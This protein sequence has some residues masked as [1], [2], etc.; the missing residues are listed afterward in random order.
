MTRNTQKNILAVVVIIGI[1]CAIFWQF[2]FKGLHPYPGNFMLAWFEPWKS[3][4]TTNGTILIAHKPVADDVFRQLYPFK[5]LAVNMLKHFEVP[6]W[7]PYN[8]SG[9]PLFATM[10][11]G[12]LN[13]FN[14]LFFFLPNYLAWSWYIIAQLAFVGFFTYLY[15]RKI[16]LSLFGALFSS[17]AFMLSGFVVTRVILGEY[18]YPLSIL[19]LLLYSV[20]TYLENPYSRKNFLI[21]FIVLFLFLSGHPHMIFYVIATTIIYIFYRFFT[22]KNKNQKHEFKHLLLLIILVLI[23]IGLSSIQLVPTIELINLSNLNTHSS[24]FIFDRFLLPIQHFVSILIPNY[25]GNQATYNYWGMADYI[26]TV[27]AI[28]TIPCFLAFLGIVYKK[29]NDKNLQYFFFLIIILTIVV[30]IDWIGSRILYSIPLP[31][32][33]TGVPTRIFALTTFSIAILAGYGFDAWWRTKNISRSNLLRTTTFIVAISTIGLGTVLL[34]KMNAPCNN[35]IIENCRT[36]ALRNTI[37]E[38]SFF[39][40]ALCILITAIKLKKT[41]KIYA[42]FA[43]LLL[44]TLIGFYNSSKYLPFSS[45]GTFHPQNDL[46]KTIKTKTHYERTFGIGH[47][48]IKTNFAT[49]FRFFDPNYYEPLYIS[50]Y[51]EL[52]TF[53]NTGNVPSQPPRSDVEVDNEINLMKD[54]RQRR[55]RLFNLLGVG[56]FIFKKSEITPN[57]EKNILWENQKWKITENVNALPRVYLVNNYEVIQSRDKI[58]QRLFDPKFNYKNSVILEEKPDFYLSQKR[59]SVNSLTVKEYKENS[60]F[61]EAHSNE[62]GILV[63]SD[64][65]YPGWKAYIDGKETKIYRANYTFRSIALPKNKHTIKFNYEPESFKIGTLVSLSSFI[66]LF[67]VFIF[68]PKVSSNKD[69]R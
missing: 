39:F 57:S 24:L 64:N 63:L 36:I 28:G 19:P 18:I 30:T 42:S 47:A 32:I 68:R 40:I 23:G 41:I 66:L 21:P 61:I 69:N 27:A 56:Y 5:T 46:I 37:L 8:G 48:N 22:G 7:N 4:N 67:I 1:T 45:Y 3:D 43:L 11:H 16:G 35:P 51:G 59:G 9:M 49:N 52:V 50:R 53:S 6:L 55:D 31:I 38:I 2:F 25:F 44:I 62:D 14:A 13:P 12:F 10:H 20:E 60:L 58:L 17:V 34:Y 54:E 15:S 29:K 33:S 26:E 65:Y